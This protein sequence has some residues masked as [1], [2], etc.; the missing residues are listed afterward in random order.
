MTCFYVV[1]C[2][3]C[4]E[5]YVR[6]TRCLVKEQT[7]IY[8]HHIRQ[9]QY[10]YFPVEKYLL[11]CGDGDFDLVSFIKILQDNQSLGKS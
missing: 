8:R 1:I 11:T 5:E 4:N 2:Q 9:P 10:E 7:N 6:E 3:G